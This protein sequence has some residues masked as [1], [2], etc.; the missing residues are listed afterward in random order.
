M[1]IEGEE[2]EAQ[3]SVLEELLK[4]TSFTKGIQEDIKI[5]DRLVQKDNLFYGPG[6]I[7]VNGVRSEDWPR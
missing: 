2:S 1:D 6:T 3:V 4:Q 5:L 7:S